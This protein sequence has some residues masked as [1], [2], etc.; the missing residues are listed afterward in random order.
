MAEIDVRVA[1]GDGPNAVECEDEL[2]SLLRWLG[3][4]ESLGRLRGQVAGDGPPAPGTM[5]TG[6][7]VLQLTIGS[8]LSSAALIVSILQWRDARRTRPVLTLR[9]GAVEVDIPVD[10]AADPETVRGIVELLDEP[11][12]GTGRAEPDGETGGD[13]G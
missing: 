8:G 2:R 13:D 9:R 3:E 12:R 1:A 5:G 4:D 11:G 7:D 10:M 6:F